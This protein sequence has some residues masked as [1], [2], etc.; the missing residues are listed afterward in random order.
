MP[1]CRYCGTKLNDNDKICGNCGNEVKPK[2]PQSTQL[3]NEPASNA[4]VNTIVDNDTFISN[5]KKSKTP[6]IIALLVLCLAAIVG[7]TLYF[8]SNENDK[9][10]KDESD[11]SEQT[12]TSSE[13]DSSSKNCDKTQVDEIEESDG[14]TISN[15]SEISEIV[16][17]NWY[18]HTCNVTPISP[19][20]SAIVRRIETEEEV[21]AWIKYSAMCTKCGSVQDISTGNISKWLQEKYEEYITNGTPI[22]LA[23]ETF[24]CDDCG[25]YTENVSFIITFE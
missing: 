15:D 5:P 8:L 18:D 22:T 3:V 13:E 16:Y 1:F 6:I 14:N 12:S 7:T 21:T 10:K 19:A 24:Y 23:G 2:L 9:I 17:D 11:S 25:G 20:I 4:K